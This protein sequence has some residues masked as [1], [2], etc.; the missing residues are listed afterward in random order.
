MVHPFALW[1]APADDERM[2]S[3]ARGF[4]DDPA[5]Y[6]TGDVYLNFIGDE[7]TARVR[8]GYGARSYERLARV[9]R[10]WDPESVFR[11]SGYVA[12]S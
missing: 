1:E 4:R 8:A 11:A 2:I 12:P 3:W 7:G 10:R 9:K 5:E 6:V